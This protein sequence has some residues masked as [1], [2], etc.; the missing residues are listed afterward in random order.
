MAQCEYPACEAD[1]TVMRTVNGPHGH[2]WA[3]N[4][5]EGHAKQLDQGMSMTVYVYAM[6]V[7]SQTTS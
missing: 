4:V 1:A 6:Q 2:S 3:T 5:C 7:A